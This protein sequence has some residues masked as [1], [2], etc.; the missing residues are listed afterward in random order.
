MPPV[1]LSENVGRLAPNPVGVPQGFAEPDGA[2]G[3]RTGDDRGV[4][5]VGVGVG[6][7]VGDGVGVWVG[8][9]GTVPGGAAAAGFGPKNTVIGGLGALKFPAA[10]RWMASIECV[11]LGAPV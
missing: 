5:G 1:T 8:G 9:G 7:G 6:V 4:T 3:G 11:P 2:D 10:S